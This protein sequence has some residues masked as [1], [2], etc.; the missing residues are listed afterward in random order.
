MQTKYYPKA[1]V[2]ITGVDGGSMNRDGSK[3]L[4]LH[5]TETSGGFYTRATYYHIQVWDDNGT[6]RWR[7]F[8][9]FD[10]ASRALRNDAGTVLQTNRDGD[11]NINVAVVGYARHTPDMSDALLRALA[12]FF[13][14]AEQEWKI[15]AAFPYAFQGGEAYGVNGVGRLKPAQ[16]DA[17]NGILGHQD[18]PDG[19]THWDP[20]KLAVPKLQ[21]L[22]AELLEPEEEDDIVTNL[23]VL[24]LY[25]GYSS[26]GKAHERDDVRTLQG[27]LAARGFAPQDPNSVKAN[28]FDGYLGPGTLEALKKFQA[29]KKLT[30]TGKTEEPTW[31]AL[32]LV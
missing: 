32:L 14:W 24:G 1:H 21:A 10:R 29:A 19:N 5:T 7:Q 25:S 12:E 28:G 9:P 31:R 11:V 17:A 22:I 15:P 27:C 18:V 6:I 16:W 2:T 20:G 8:I 26:K 13:V 4:V 30:V 3:K 23:P